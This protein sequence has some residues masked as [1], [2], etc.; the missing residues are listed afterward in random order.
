MGHSHADGFWCRCTP[1][2]QWERLLTTTPRG[3]IQYPGPVACICLKSN[4]FENF[5]T[6][7][8]LIFRHDIKF[9][10]R[11]ELNET[12]IQALRLKYRDM[13]L[14]TYMPCWRG[15]RGQKKRR[16][17]SQHS[18]FSTAWCLCLRSTEQCSW[19]GGWPTADR[20]MHP[21][22]TATPSLAEKRE[23]DRECGNE[24]DGGAVYARARTQND[25]K[26]I[27]MKTNG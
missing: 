27:L 2:D 23:Q 22:S 12:R 3:K 5:Y 8:I 19:E 26:S 18:S 15:Q 9:V 21:D 4:E 13:M 25:G 14:F 10:F 6:G 17:C 1:I 7:T 24:E 11:I 20:E 16:G